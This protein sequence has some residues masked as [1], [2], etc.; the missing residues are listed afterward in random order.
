VNITIPDSIE[1]HV[2]G[3]CFKSQFGRACHGRTPLLPFNWNITRMVENSITPALTG[4]DP[5]IK[6]DLEKVNLKE[7]AIKEIEHKAGKG[8][9]KPA[10]ID[11]LAWGWPLAEW[12]KPS[13]LSAGEDGRAMRSVLFKH[14]RIFDDEIRKGDVTAVSYNVV[15]ITMVAGIVFSGIRVLWLLFNGLEDEVNF[16]PCWLGCVFLGMPFAILAILGAT[17]KAVGY[18]SSGWREN[19]CNIVEYAATVLRPYWVSNY[20]TAIVSLM[21]CTKEEIVH[22]LAPVVLLEPR[23]SLWC[24]R[25]RIPCQRSFLQIQS[26]GPAE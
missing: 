11:M 19:G 8:K 15:L 21:T 6:A 25:L 10:T 23:C 2:F 14:E 17:I 20:F 7:D 16:V 5:R 24:F 3:A 22:G 26:L 13:S 12:P 4:L 1:L 18:G 9:P